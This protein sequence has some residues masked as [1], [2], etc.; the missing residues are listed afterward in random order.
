[1][2][3]KFEGCW[4]KAHRASTF[5]RPEGNSDSWDRTKLS[6]VELAPMTGAM[7][8]FLR[9]RRHSQT[10]VVSGKAGGVQAAR[11]GKR[12]GQIRRLGR[13]AVSFNPRALAILRAE[14]RLRGPSS[15]L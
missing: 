11:S 4:P 7:K 15:I 12:M 9:C 14:R 8:R 13:F 2:R 6:N 3:R 1:M 5:A 10:A